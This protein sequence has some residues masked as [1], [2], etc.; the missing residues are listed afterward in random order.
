MKQYKTSYAWKKKIT[1]LFS[2]L[3][4]TDALDKQSHKSHTCRRIHPL[5]NRNLW[6]KKAVQSDKVEHTFNICYWG[7]RKAFLFRQRYPET[8]SYLLWKATSVFQWPS[9]Y[10]LH[11][12]FRALNGENVEKTKADII[13]DAHENVKLRVYDL[14]QYTHPSL[15]RSDFP[16]NLHERLSVQASAERG[17]IHQPWT[18]GGSES[19]PSAGLQRYCSL[20]STRTSS[21]KG[22]WSSVCQA[23]MK[24]CLSVC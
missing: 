9:F 24:M 7:T 2:H 17:W 18:W 11:L 3:R 16:L 6:S 23:C 14:L 8:L 1:F 21:Q 13:E 19:A 20:Q 12:I 5:R 22:G 10:I 4:I 15:N